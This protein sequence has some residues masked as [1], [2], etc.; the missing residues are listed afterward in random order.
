[1]TDRSTLLAHVALKLG[2][3]PE[4]IA[5]E[6][7]G[8]IL[9]S[10]A[11]AVRA[12][13][14]VL[15]TG[16]ADVGRLSK[17]RTQASDEEGTRPDLAGYDDDRAERVLIEAKFWAGLTDPASRIPQAFAAD[18]PSALLFV[19]PAA[20]SETLWTNCASALSSRESSS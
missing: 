7:L 9:S 8:Y 13:E 6:A 18:R 5:V 11:P 15:R 1:M 19:A 16:G 14:D 17:V 3:H 20:R 4:N 10:S 2:V 12:L